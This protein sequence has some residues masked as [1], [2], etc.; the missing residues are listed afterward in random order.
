VFE[1]STRG[2]SVAKIT[3]IKLALHQICADESVPS[4]LTARILGKYGVT[5][6]EV[7]DALDYAEDAL[8]ERRHY[9]DA[10]ATRAMADAMQPLL[11]RQPT[12]QQQQAAQRPQTL[13]YLLEDDG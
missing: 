10:E 8:V 11:P 9:E 13:D 5:R 6:S 4:T 3:N 2:L 7:M 1:Y 12:A